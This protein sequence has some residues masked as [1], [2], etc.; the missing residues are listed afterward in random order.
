MTFLKSRLVSLPDKSFSNT[1]TQR[2]KR[3]WSIQLK[4]R[5][6]WIPPQISMATIITITRNHAMIPHLTKLYGYH[7]HLQPLR[8]FPNLCKSSGWQLC[9][10]PWEIMLLSLHWLLT[11]HQNHCLFLRMWPMPFYSPGEIWPRVS[12]NI[13]YFQILLKPWCGQ[14]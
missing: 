11:H 8:P 9:Q 3:H 10:V 13:V 5:Q 2:E 14:F 4:M 12:K 1:K 7:G 6:W